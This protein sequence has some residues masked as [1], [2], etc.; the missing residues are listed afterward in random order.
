MKDIWNF[1][2]RVIMKTA[3]FII[4]GNVLIPAGWRI[5]LPALLVG[6]ICAVLSKIAFKE[7]R[8]FNVNNSRKV[9]LVSAAIKSVLGTVLL[10]LLIMYPQ[11]V[12]PLYI[13]KMLLTGL[14]L[15][16]TVKVEPDPEKN[17]KILKISAS[18]VIVAIA[19]AIAI[20]I[21]YHPSPSQVYGITLLFQLSS[22]FRHF[23]L[24]VKEI[25]NIT[26]YS[27]TLDLGLDVITN[28]M[29]VVIVY[30]ILISKIQQTQ[31]LI[32]ITFILTAV[33]GMWIFKMIDPVI[34]SVFKERTSSI[35]VS[36]L[37]L[38]RLTYFILV[39]TLSRSY[40]TLY[41]LRLYTGNLGA[42]FYLKGTEPN[43]LEDRGIWF[44]LSSFAIVAAMSV[45]I[46][47]LV[48]NR[49][50]PDS[51]QI[52]IIFLMSQAILTSS[53]IAYKIDP[54]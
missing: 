16:F 40:A 42:Q 6:L 43:N 20:Q 44:S 2:V 10:L 9:G 22:I 14:F 3:S 50:T 1:I 35:Y 29:S 18:S 11:K 46:G 13:A 38:T 37:I 41:L 39:A 4:I 26:S 31:V 15:Y 36:V 23:S 7:S 45:S 51:G 25:N 17:L 32:A 19:G 47:A 27:K 5:Y 12:L 8:E 28:S 48:W 24:G 21:I 54:P 33:F 53:L 34:T 49:L 30:S 52:F